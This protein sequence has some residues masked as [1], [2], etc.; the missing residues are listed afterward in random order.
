MEGQEHLLKVLGGTPGIE[1][2]GQTQS[3]SKDREYYL[4]LLK[5]I[6]KERWSVTGIFGMC[7][8]MLPVVLSGRKNRLKNMGNGGQTNE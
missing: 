3:R 7:R 6:V 8:N 5:E 4:Q 2:M 1:S